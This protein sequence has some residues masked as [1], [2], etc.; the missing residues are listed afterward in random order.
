LKHD[1]LSLLRDIRD[2]RIE[3]GSRQGQDILGKAFKEDLS[4]TLRMT[5][6]LP[7]QFL[8][9]GMKLA[10]FNSAEI[11][12]SLHRDPLARQA[13][14][15]RERR[16]AEKIGAIDHDDF[17]YPLGFGSDDGPSAEP[18]IEEE[19]DDLDPFASP[20]REMRRGP[21]MR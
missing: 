20:D 17:G 13:F 19:D 10:G 18:E 4:I 7:K 1:L 2:G 6:A 16:L 5:E 14:H 11:G 3:P 9:R 21:R 12:H 8:E 15:E